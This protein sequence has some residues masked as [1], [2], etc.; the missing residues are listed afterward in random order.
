M[1]LLFD[2]IQ[3]SGQGTV[4]YLSLDADIQTASRRALALANG[5]SERWHPAASCARAVDY[6]IEYGDG[7][8]KLLF[9]TYSTTALLCMTSADAAAQLGDDDR[10]DCAETLPHAPCYSFSI[11]PDA[12][13]VA[14]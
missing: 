14:E 8:L 4:R 3:L 11:T 13:R 2:H 10:G 1:A 7:C 5:S 6:A 9:C 12:L